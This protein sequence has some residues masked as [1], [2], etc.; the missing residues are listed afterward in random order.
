MSSPPTGPLSPEHLCDFFLRGA[1]PR[2]QWKVGMELEKLGRI[3]GSGEPFP[4]DGDGPTVRKV[5]ELLL[6]RR[7]GEPVTESGRIIGITAPWGAISLE[8]GGQVEWSSVPYPDLDQLE[9]AHDE[10]LAVMHEAATTLGIDWLEVGVDPEHP[11]TAMHWMPKQRYGIMRDYFKNKGRLAHRMMTQTASIQCAFDFADA[12][13]WARKFRAAAILAPLATALFA[14]SSRIDGKDSGYRSF[15]QAIWR[16]TDD[17]RCGLPAVVFDKG[18]DLRHWVEWILDVP[19]LFRRQGDELAAPDGSTFRELM[20]GPEGSSLTLDDWSTHC[21]SAFTEV[22]S[23]SYIEVRCADLQPDGCAPAV[24]AFWSAMLY[25]DEALAGALDDGAGL[26]HAGWVEAMDSA[27]R[28]GLDGSFGRFSLREM[29]TRT[30][31]SA[32]LALER[33]MPCAGDGGAVRH[34]ESLASRLSLDLG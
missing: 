30:L 19:L 20:A 29:A 32:V 11:V 9:R 16:E 18:F 21:S 5:L 31:R 12:A 27:S 4:Y 2:S 1:V 14:N 33:G 13:D 3:R 23:Y 15:R 8:P 17:D 25:D 7:G 26:D 34:L 10:H 6:E 28:Q 22:R 24:P